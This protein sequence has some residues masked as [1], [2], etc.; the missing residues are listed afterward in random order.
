MDSDELKALQAPLKERYRD[1]PEAAVVTLGAEGRM[2]DDLSCSV[3]TGRALVAAGHHPAT[4]GDGSLAC[5]GDMLLQGSP[6]AL[7]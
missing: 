2:G 4:G 3:Q 6:P 7:V 1:Q 5:A